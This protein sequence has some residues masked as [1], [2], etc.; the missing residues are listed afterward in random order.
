MT[1]EL[2][3][4]MKK[5]CMCKKDFPADQLDFLERCEPCF[6]KFMDTPEDERPDVGVPYVPIYN[7]D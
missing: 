7:G 6:R 1:D 4:P 3:P 2:V 5:C